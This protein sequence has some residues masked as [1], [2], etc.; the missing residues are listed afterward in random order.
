MNGTLNQATS[1][2]SVVPPSFNLPGLK[3]GL[4]HLLT[5]PWSEIRAS[6]L[7]LGRLEDRAG[8]QKMGEVLKSLCS[9]FISKCFY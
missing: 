3:T 7:R 5:K 2:I 6:V 1:K 4:P 9:A 8:G